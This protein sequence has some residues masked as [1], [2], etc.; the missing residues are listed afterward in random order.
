MSQMEREELEAFLN[1]QSFRFID[2]LLKSQGMVLR[3]KMLT[4]LRN[5]K[6]REA[7]EYRAAMEECLNFKNLVKKRLEFLQKGESNGVNA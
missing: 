7:G 1:S 5:H 6:D 3:D 4:S 2:N